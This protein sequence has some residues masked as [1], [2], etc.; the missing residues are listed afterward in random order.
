MPATSTTLLML[1]T[2]PELPIARYTIPALGRLTSVAGV[3]VVVFA[4]GLTVDQEQR[5][6]SWLATVPNIRLASNRERIAGSTGTMVAGEWYT[7]DAG[8]R[9]LRVGPYESAPEIWER[10]LLRLDA[11]IVGII[12]SDLEVLD[13]AFI[14][15]MIAEFGA[16]PGLGFMSVDHSPSRTIRDSYSGQHCV[17]AE[18]YHT[19]FCLYSPAALRACADFTFYEEVRDGVLHKYDHSARLQHHLARQHGYHGAVLDRRW[20]RAYLHYAAF[21]QNRSLDARRAALYRLVRIGRHDGWAHRGLPAPGALAIRAASAA[22][23]R[24]FG[25]G[26]FDHERLRYRW[27]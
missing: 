15:D 2:P 23:Y 17:L 27:T 3:S 25:L 22:C 5:V 13:G 8:R 1:L 19:W 14:A 21:A 7:T 4:N 6:A 9:E 10:E 11:G 16:D 20:R 24:L 26:R 12:D 18:R